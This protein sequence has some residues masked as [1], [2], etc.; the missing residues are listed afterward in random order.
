MNN[1]AFFVKTKFPA[2]LKCTA[3]N[4]VSAVQLRRAYL[5]KSGSLRKYVYLDR[6]Y[7]SEVGSYHAIS[8]VLEVKSY[9]RV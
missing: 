6:T 5:R 1:C 9:D 3:S 4:S 2:P 7:T 8:A